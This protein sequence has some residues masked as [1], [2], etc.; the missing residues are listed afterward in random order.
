[1]RKFLVK[2]FVGDYFA[3]LFGSTFNW[4]RAAN[5]IFPLGCANGIYLVKTESYSFESIPGIILLVK[6]VKWDELDDCQKW[7][8]GT[9]VKRGILKSKELLQK[10]K[11]REWAKLD[12]EMYNLLKKKENWNLVPLLINP[13]IMIITFLILIL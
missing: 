12:V 5:I 11:L 4:V 9:G 1:M 7:Q 8:L 3:R 13:C 6:P 2:Y 10:D